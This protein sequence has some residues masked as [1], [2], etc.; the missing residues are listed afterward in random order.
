MIFRPPVN[1]PQ[2]PPGEH[3]QWPAAATA[4]QVPTGSA[5]SPLFGQAVALPRRQR[6]LPA[7]VSVLARLVVSVRAAAARLYR[8]LADAAVVADPQLPQP[9][10]SDT[11][12]CCLSAN[13]YWQPKLICRPIV[14]CPPAS[15]RSVRSEH[16]RVL[17]RQLSAIAAD[18]SFPSLLSASRQAEG[19][20][21]WPT[22]S[23][24]P[25]ASSITAI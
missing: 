16:L 7:G 4:H 18:R 14:M 19:L 17:N 21:A 8:V 15:S 11:R 1:Q 12:R 9:G 5:R 22:T 3:H 23:T 2:T 20:C 25:P 6:V 24:P 13:G 10:G